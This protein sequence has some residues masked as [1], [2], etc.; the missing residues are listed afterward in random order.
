[1]KVGCVEKL[2]NIG[3]LGR[4]EAGEDFVSSVLMYY[5]FAEDLFQ[6]LQREPTPWSRLEE[7]ESSR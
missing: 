2:L 4:V 1:M 5:H 7:T 6:F 3:D